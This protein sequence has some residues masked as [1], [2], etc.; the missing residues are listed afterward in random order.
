MTATADKSA[1][2]AAETLIPPS[3]RVSLLVGDHQIDLLLARRGAAGQAG[4]AHPRH[5]QPATQ[6]VG[7]EELPGGAFVFARAAGMTMLSGNLSLAA[8]GVN[9]AELLAFV[10]GGDSPALRTQHRKRQRGD[11]EV[12]QRTFPG[13]DRA[14]RGPGGRRADLGRVECRRAAGVAAALGEFGRMAGADD[15]RGHRAGPCR[16]RIAGCPH[17]C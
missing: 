2:T 12:G 8:Q 7:A 10:P 15:V 14:R 9:D 3:S 11:R 16:H 17:G 13:G 4:R 6:S 1:A 5:D